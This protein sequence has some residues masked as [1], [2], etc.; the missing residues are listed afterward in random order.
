MGHILDVQ[1]PEVNPTGAPG[2]DF[3]HIERLAAAK[4]AS[5]EEVAREL[6]R[7]ALDANP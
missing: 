3:Q 5:R 4:H 7:R 2:D 1:L 6:I